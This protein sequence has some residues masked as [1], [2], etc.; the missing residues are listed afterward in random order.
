MR[1]GFYTKYTHCDQAYLCQRLV[2]LLRQLGLEFDIYSDATAGKFG[3]PYDCAVVTKSIIKFTQWVKKQDAVIWTHVPKVEQLSF[4]ARANKL[5]VVAPMWQELQPPF[6]KALR[7]ADVVVAFSAECAELY[8]DEYRLR[9]VVHLPYDTGLPIT[10]KLSKV[11]SRCV[12][13]FLPWFDRY[14]KCASSSFLTFV[15]HMF[16][17]MPDAQLTAGVTSS[18]FSPAI[19]K[20]FNNLSHKTNGR[21]QLVRNVSIAQRTL[22]F[23]EH[24]LTLNPAEC[25]NYG[26]CGLT[27][28]NCGTPVLSFALSPQIDFIRPDVNGVLVKTK[29]NYDL[30]GVPFADPDYARLFAVLQVLIAEPEHIDAL[31]KSVTHNLSARRKAFEEGWQGILQLN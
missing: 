29:T 3:P 17:N 5:T 31:N 28:I 23:S 1:V 8:R 22:L 10:K 4:A 19:A 7:R 11:N 16:I 26:F 30:N 6:K 27:S 13:I 9:N 12:K 20:F 18:R 24:D 25:D 14:A 21:V 2:N 15:N